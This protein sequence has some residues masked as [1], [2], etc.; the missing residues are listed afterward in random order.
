MSNRYSDKATVLAIILLLISTVVIDTH[1]SY[2]IEQEKRQQAR[3]NLEQVRHCLDKGLPIMA[4]IEVFN[5]CI[6]KSRTSQTGDVYVFDPYT[7]E[8]IY[9]TSV[10][11]PL[12]K[13]MSFTK[14]S[15]GQIFKDWHS[16]EVAI[17]HIILGKDSKYGDNAKY[18]FD[19]DWEWLEWIYYPEEAT[20]AFTNDTP[21]VIVQGTQ[22]DEIFKRYEGI[23]FAVFLLISFISLLL[24][25]TIKVTHRRR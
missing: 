6:S 19:D 13:Q 14:E 9:D 2:L 1:M 12:H 21:Y 11:I 4:E 23:R 15:L 20:K 24:L 8:G 22:R 18:L 25:S 7:L 5:Q 17:E 3:Y 16:A 10:D